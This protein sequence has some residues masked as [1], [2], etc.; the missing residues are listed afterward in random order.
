MRPEDADVGAFFERLH[1]KI[2]ARDPPRRA[3]V[4]RFI[5]QCQSK[6]DA[7][8]AVTLLKAYRPWMPKLEPA[9]GTLLIRACLR[10]DDLDLALQVLHAH[11][12]LRA[13]L[14]KAACVDL[15]TALSKQGRTD[16]M[17]TAFAYMR[18]AQPAVESSKT[19]VVLVTGLGHAGQ[20]GKA[21]ELLLQTRAAGVKASA[22]CYRVLLKACN[23]AL[24]ADAP[25]ARPAAEAARA[26]IGKL[27][28][29]D[30]IKDDEC[31]KL[32]AFSPATTV[33]P[34]ADKTAEAPDSQ[35]TAV[36]DA[37]TAEKKT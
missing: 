8:K 20:V 5:M 18:V 28:T 27:M 16:D 2:Q 37:E 19:L 23:A 24:D 25:D 10:S 36:G 34:N 6:E 9:A 7:M 21:V 3:D 11:R 1:A 14:S 12:Q 22:F 29:E 35:E 31:A 30:K 32:L 33:A 4:M 15:L 13:S 17:L 26:K